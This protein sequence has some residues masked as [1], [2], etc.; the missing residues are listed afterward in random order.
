[1]ATDERHTTIGE[2]ATARRNG[3]TARRHARPDQL[4]HRELLAALR[5]FKRGNFDVQAARRP[6]RRRRSDRRD[7]QRARRDGEAR[8]RTRRT[9]SATPSA[10]KA[11]RSKRMRR[12]GTT[13]GWADYIPSV[14]E[15]IEDLSGHANEI[16]RV[17]T[18]VAKRR[19]RADDG[20]R[21]RRPRSAARRVPSPRDASSTAWWPGSRSSAPR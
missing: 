8:S 6:D 14:N 12:L 15:V 2:R 19:P 4:N 16:A 3:A 1:M 10:R 13:G 21:G 18:A 17:V 5:A 20:R 11:R 7:V 9:T